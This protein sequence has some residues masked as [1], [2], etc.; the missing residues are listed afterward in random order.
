MAIDTGSLGE[1]YRR[2]ARVVVVGR[3]ALVR[4]SAL[5]DAV[6]VVAWKGKGGRAN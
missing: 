4:C 3:H 1:T 6:Y 5:Y 2:L